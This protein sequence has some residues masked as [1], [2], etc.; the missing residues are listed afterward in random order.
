MQFPQI[1]IQ[2]GY[3]KLGLQTTRAQQSIEQP[4][5]SL[6]MSQKHVSIEID[7]VEGKLEIDS[8]KAWSALGRARFEEVTDRIA[9]ASLQISMQN[10]AEIAQNGDRMM[11][12]NE[13]GNVFADLARQNV[14]KERP[15]EIAG[16]PGYDNVDI[17]YTPGQIQMNYIPGGVKFQPEVHRPVIDYYP[18][19][20]N[21]YLISQN[22]IFLSVL[23]QQLDAVV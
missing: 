6:N 20:V 23:G 18:G 9:Q 17:T 12:I 10:I 16:E 8:R 5:S 15:I 4:R 1:Q 11:A 2:Q 21:P 19:K 13:N 22:F 7:S 14:F 3:S